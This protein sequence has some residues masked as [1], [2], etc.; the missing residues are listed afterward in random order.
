MATCVFELR[1][2]FSVVYMKSNMSKETEKPKPVFVLSVLLILLKCKYFSCLPQTEPPDVTKFYVKD[3]KIWIVN[4]TMFTSKFCEMDF[5][6]TTSMKYAFFDRSYLGNHTTHKEK[7][8]GQFK[9]T[10]IS[11]VYD[12]MMVAQYH[13]TSFQSM[14]QLLYS[15]QS[16]TCGI[17]NVTLFTEPRGS[18]YDMRVKQSEVAHPNSS[19]IEMFEQ[20]SERRNVTTLY[21]NTCQTISQ[22]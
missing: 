22:H 19:C 12:A 1:V 21:N 18:Y 6:W 7:L 4:T 9:K 3:A 5:V 2:Q 10:D 15:Y 13:G 14:D 17:F 11:K 8:L 16:Y 20:L